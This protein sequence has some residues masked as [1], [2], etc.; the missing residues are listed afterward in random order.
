MPDATPPRVVRV[1]PSPSALIGRVQEVLAV[2]SEPLDVASLTAQVF[3]ILH[4]GADGVFGTA[5]DYE[6]SGGA[7]NYLESL[8]AA[9]L[10]FNNPLP[11]GNYR[12]AVRAP[13]A[14]RAG[15]AMLDSFTWSFRVFDATDSDGDGI[16]D[17]LEAALGF[18]PARRDTNGNGIP[19]GMEDLDG[20]SLPTAWEIFY[21]YDP[22]KR[23]TD[24]NGI[25]DGREDPDRDYLVNLDEYRYGTDPF[26]PDS[27]G[28][29][30]S[31]E[32]EI[33]GGSDP[34][35]PASVPRPQMTA[36]PT[37]SAFRV[38]VSGTIASGLYSAQPSVQVYK[39]DLTAVGA[40]APGMIQSRP[41]LT[42]IRPSAE[43]TLDDRGVIIGRPPVQVRRTE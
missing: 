26:N 31:D 36:R 38:S 5:D 7:L 34:L 17:E 2:F 19:D 8:N 1:S 12:P 33:A 15:N 16:P 41:P 10:R 40:L 21:G 14:D 28:D 35:N 25:P 13:I 27:D 30:W 39:P 29:G 3:R 9:R 32:V 23:D 24:G 6:I 43:G 18:D 22:L 37:L 20:D 42:V 11:P 4:A